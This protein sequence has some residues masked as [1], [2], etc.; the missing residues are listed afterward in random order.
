MYCKYCGK[1]I[2]DDSRFCKECGGKQDGAVEISAT[3][4]ET[5]NVEGKIGV[6]IT[7][8]DIKYVVL[9]TFIKKNVYWV[10]SYCLWFLL[11]LIFLI[12]GDDHDSFWPHI[13][14]SYYHQKTKIEFDLYYYGP[15]EFIIYVFIIPLAIYLIFTWDRKQRI[16]KEKRFAERKKSIKNNGRFLGNPYER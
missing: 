9:K 4:P 15:P 1:P 16:R 2:A 5:V 3:I 6:S 7:H 13:Y 11:N 10:I 12:T 14:Q 8:T